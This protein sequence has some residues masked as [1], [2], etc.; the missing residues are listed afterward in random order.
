VVEQHVSSGS[1]E[2][3]RAIGQ[4]AIGVAR[5]RAVESRRPDRLF[6]DPLAAA[7]V[8]AAGGDF[9][10]PPSSSTM[11]VRPMRDAYVAIRTRFFDEA[12]LSASDDNIGQ[13]VILGAGLDARAFRLP[14]HDGT[15][16][17]ELDMADVFEFKERVLA[18]QRVYPRCERIVLPVDLRDDW[19]AAL[20][21]SK[22]R[23]DQASIW[24][25]EGVLM[26]LSQAER[27]RL[28]EQISQLADTASRMAVEPPTWRIPPGVAATVA[29]GK[30]DRATMAMAAQLSQAAAEEASVADPAGWL[31][32]W[33][34][35]V[36]LYDVAERFAAYGREPPPGVANMLGAGP[37]RWL[38][39][40]E[41]TG[42]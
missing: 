34:W 23:A 5:A 37:R 42:P 18:E 26:Y 8:E 11:D 30:L 40:A 19:P 31:S 27:D 2:L 4:T 29:R 12:L 33:G 15:R 20:R 21:S 38:A 13:V 41:R 16:L 39:T 28:I 32:R 10:A 1:A 7:F 25:L 9:D 35:R 24:L 14:W 3:P 17:F 36:Q 22:F 6:D